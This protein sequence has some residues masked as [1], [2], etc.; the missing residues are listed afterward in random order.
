MTKSL[1]LFVHGIMGSS[2][3]SWGKFPDLIRTDRELAARFDAELDD[4]PGWPKAHPL[5]RSGGLDVAADG[6]KTRIENLYHAYG[7]IAVIAHSQGGVIALRYILN[8]IQDDRQLPVRRLI[9]FVSPFSGAALAGSRHFGEQG[10]DLAPASKFMFEFKKDWERLRHRIPVAIRAVVGGQDGVVAPSSAMAVDPDYEMIHGCDHGSIVKPQSPEAESFLIA[11]RFLLRALPRPEQS[12]PQVRR[13]MVLRNEDRRRLANER[14]QLSAVPLTNAW[15]SEWNVGREAFEARLDEALEAATP[16]AWRGL[17]VLGRK[18]R[19]TIRESAQ[20]PHNLPPYLD[21]LT[22]CTDVVDEAFEEAA[23]ISTNFCAPEHDHLIARI[24]K[25]ERQAGDER[26]GLEAGSLASSITS[27]R[28][29]HIDELFTRL[30]DVEKELAVSKKKAI[31]VEQVNVVN[32]DPASIVGLIRDAL[33]ALRHGLDLLDDKRFTET[34]RKGALA[35]WRA[36]RLYS[37]AVRR[38]FETFKL[39]WR[40]EEVFEDFERLEPSFCLPRQGEV[41]LQSDQPTTVQRSPLEGFKHLVGMDE[42]YAELERLEAMLAMQSERK[43][44]GLGVDSSPGLHAAVFGPPGTGK[45]TVARTIAK[46]Y[47]HHSAL[48]GAS[49]DHPVFHVVSR[50]DLVGRW[51]G[52]TAIKTRKAC[53]IADGGVLFVSEVGSLAGGG[54]DFGREAISELIAC[55]EIRRDRLAVIFAGHS[56]DIA[57]FIH[58]NVGLASR[59]PIHIPRRDYTDSELVEIAVVLAKK[60]GF[61]IAPDALLIIQER[62][63]EHRAGCFRRHTAFGNARDVQTLIE[64]AIQEQIIRLGNKGYRSSV[65]LNLLTAHDVKAARLIPPLPKEPP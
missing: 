50:A 28:Q 29:R 6:L 49:S 4:Y 56:N 43:R 23:G 13:P 58:T 45:T 27:A 15:Q 34:L 38:R 16:E 2:A 64:K 47:H 7:D 40:Q 10:E 41:P 25:L 35:T 26:V 24:E 14:E 30:D 46:L 44:A 61:R 20:D 51:V 60:Q 5:K 62:M 31:Q 1:I 11:K 55:M 63:E 8:C 19:K 36:G 53:D 9:A 59:I 22:A 3:G 52:E 32:A 12:R 57:S 17:S 48:S 54:D 65:D 33:E 18:L 37:S 39:P 21:K 42:T